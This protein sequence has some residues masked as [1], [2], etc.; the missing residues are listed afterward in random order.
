MTAP[1]RKDVDAMANLLRTL[2]GERPVSNL[3]ESNT[4][5]QVSLTPG[6]GNEDVK[7]MEK[8]LR[9]LNNATNSVSQ[10]VV[11][12]I[13]E[14]KKIQTG[15][16]I[17]S[18]TVEK[19]V[20][21]SYDIRD[22]RTGDTLFESIRLYETAYVIVAYMNEGKKINSKEITQIIS[23]NAVFENYYYDALTHKHTF[24][25]AKKKGDES[26]MQ[27]SEAR[28][29]RAKSEASLAKNK[30]KKIYEAKQSTKL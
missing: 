29:G 1:S 23:A 14:T 18:F 17:G 25:V 22:V 10:K 27:I 26:K 16:S 5:P 21:D 20:S 2:K 7:A 19:N 3:V 11:N 15:V 30:I 28:F 6:I 8:I 4:T 9:S 12:T 24:N 13:S